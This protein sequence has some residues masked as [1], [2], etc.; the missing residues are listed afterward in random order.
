MEEKQVINITLN[1]T[2]EEV[3]LVLSCVA[4]QPYE[5]VAGLIDKIR[6]QGIPQVPQEE[7][8]PAEGGTD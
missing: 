8:A 6:A 4:K 5:A 2:L 7:P 1:L 3:N